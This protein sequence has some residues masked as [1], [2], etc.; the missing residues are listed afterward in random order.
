MEIQEFTAGV[1]LAGSGLPQQLFG[2]GV[3]RR[4]TR[5]LLLL[6]PQKRGKSDRKI[7]SAVTR[8]LELLADMVVGPRKKCQKNRMGPQALPTPCKCSRSFQKVRAKQSG[9]VFQAVTAHHWGT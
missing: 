7:S 6:T 1:R 3:R 2:V 4:H 9:T 5:R 8:G